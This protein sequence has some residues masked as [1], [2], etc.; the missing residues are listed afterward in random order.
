M[1]KIETN[2]TIFNAA[3]VECFT[4]NSYK[5]GSNGVCNINCGLC[6][7][8]LELN[9]GID[10]VKHRRKMSRLKNISHL[11]ISKISLQN[12]V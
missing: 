3:Y 4:Y 7:I 5:L 1:G 9:K 10:L 6:D 8:T 12:T 11:R 2:V